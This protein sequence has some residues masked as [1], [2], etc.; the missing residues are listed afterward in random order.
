[1]CRRCRVASGELVEDAGVPFQRAGAKRRRSL[2]SIRAAGLVFALVVVLATLSSIRDRPAAARMDAPGA[3][4]SSAPSG[5]RG[6]HILIT[7]P[8][9][10]SAAPGN[11]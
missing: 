3:A 5:G 4:S 2:V 6:V 10:G 9:A 11:K 1:M 8:P 7:P